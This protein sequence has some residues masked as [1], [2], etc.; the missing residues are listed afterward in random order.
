LSILLSRLFNKKKTVKYPTKREIEERN[1]NKNIIMRNIETI[2][3]EIIPPDDYQHR[4]GF[5]N[6]SYIDKLNDL[7]KIQVEDELINMFQKSDDL[8]IADTLAYMK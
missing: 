2:I 4:N 5:C 6:E 3:K 7:E 1:F 8:L